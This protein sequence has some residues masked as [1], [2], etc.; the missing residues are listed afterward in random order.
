MHLDSNEIPG[1]KA[2]WEFHKDITCYVEQILEAA[3]YKIAAL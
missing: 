1:E 3:P 2:R